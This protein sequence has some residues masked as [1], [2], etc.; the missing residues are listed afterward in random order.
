MRLSWRLGSHHKAVWGMDVV[1]DPDVMDKAIDEW[2]ND[3]TG[4]EQMLSRDAL[5]EV[6]ES[7]PATFG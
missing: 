3:M 2:W 5:D 4:G 1:H 7:L 6:C